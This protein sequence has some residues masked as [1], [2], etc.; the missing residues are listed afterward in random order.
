MIFLKNFLLIIFVK[1]MA[2]FSIESNGRL[3]KTAI[4]F[5]GEQIGGVKEIFLNL[6]E[7][8][9]FDSIIQYEGTNKQL[10]SKNIFNE[11]LENIKIVEPSFTEEEAQSLQLLTIESDGDIENSVVYF[12]EEQIDGIVSIFVHIKGVSTNNGLSSIFSFKKNIPEHVE[13]RADITFRN[14]DDSIETENIF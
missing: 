11:Y 8:G 5:N 3:E 10:Y 6:D 9:T 2:T 14:E 1:I 7:N 13:F 12:N 4:Y